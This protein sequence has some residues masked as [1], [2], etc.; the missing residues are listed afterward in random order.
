MGVRRGL[1]NFGTLWPRRFGKWWVTPRNTLLLTPHLC[2]RAKFGHSRSNDTSV[3]TEIRH[4]DLTSRVRLSRS[5]KAIGTDTDRSA[6]NDFQLIMNNKLCGKPR[7]MPPPL[8]AAR[9]SPAPAHTRLTPAAPSAPYAM[10]I[11]DRQATDRSGRKRRN[12]WRPCKLCSDLNSQPK[13]PGEL[14]H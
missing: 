10:N 1:K 6:T 5:F 9:Y 7:N 2:Y 8:Y 13:R 3:I 14:D 11:H 12:W 4:K